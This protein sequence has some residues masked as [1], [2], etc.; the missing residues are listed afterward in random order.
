MAL[1]ES[2]NLFQFLLIFAHNQILDLTGH[3]DLAYNID[4]LTVQVL[5]IE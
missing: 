3:L 4:V 2:K 5:F 1:M